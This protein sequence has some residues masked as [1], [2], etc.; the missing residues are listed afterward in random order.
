MR[1]SIGATTLDL[2]VE[3]SFSL[4]VLFIFISLDRQTYIVLN[5]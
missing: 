2:K 5:Q 1:V 3:A 4:P